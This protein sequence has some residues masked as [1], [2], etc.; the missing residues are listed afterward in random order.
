MRISDWSSDVCSSDLARS[1]RDL[2]LADMIAGAKRIAFR[3]EEDQ[4]PFLLIIMKPG[5]DDRQRRR[6]QAAAAEKQPERK[7][8]KKHDRDAA[9]YDHQRGAEIGLQ[10][11]QRDRKSTRL[12]SSP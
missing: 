1:D 11:H 9:K 2:R 8:G 3:I 12:N 10:Y 6:D 4:H 7:T 5:K